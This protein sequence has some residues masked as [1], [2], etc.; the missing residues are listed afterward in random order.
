MGS[1]V[2]AYME[3][4][5]PVLLQLDLDL[6][7]FRLIGNRA[8]HNTTGVDSIRTLLLAEVCFTISFNG[9]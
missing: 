1:L 7:T 2:C 8:V 5:R 9:L 3:S 6:G 4:N